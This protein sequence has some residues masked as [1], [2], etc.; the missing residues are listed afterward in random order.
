MNA[1]LL[2]SARTKRGFLLYLLEG[3]QE[4]LDDFKLRQGKYY[5]T[6]E[7]GQPI[8]ITGGFSGHSGKLVY[9]NGR[10]VIDIRKILFL[11]NKFQYDGHN[12]WAIIDHCIDNDPRV[13]LR[14]SALSWRH[15]RQND[16]SLNISYYQLQH[17]LKE[18]LLDALKCHNINVASHINMDEK[19]RDDLGFEFSERQKY[20]EELQ[21]Y[22]WEEKEYQRGLDKSIKDE[23]D[24][25]GEDW[26]WNID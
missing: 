5:R 17:N 8:F 23:F 21:S 11:H 9:F 2:S 24:S 3:S 10:Y 26:H 22:D 20:Y 16:P 1:T 15:F 19:Q 13:F 4:E 12:L 6:T 18:L 7:S 14:N 25:W